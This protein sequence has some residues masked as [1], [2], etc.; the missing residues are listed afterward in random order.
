MKRFFLFFAALSLLTVGSSLVNATTPDERIFGGDLD[1]GYSI[2]DLDF[3][4]IAGS[5]S[6]DVACYN[7]LKK[8]DPEAKIAFFP[9]DI[10][11]AQALAES[12]GVCLILPISESQSWGYKFKPRTPEKDILFFV[13]LAQWNTSDTER[14]WYGTPSGLSQF[15]ICS[16]VGDSTGKILGPYGPNVEFVDCY[17]TANFRSFVMSQVAGKFSFVRRRAQDMWHM[18]LS[19][20]EVRLV[21]RMLAGP[22]A[23]DSLGR[24]ESLCGVIDIT[25]SKVD[26]ALAEFQ[27]QRQNSIAGVDCPIEVLPEQV[28]LHGNYPN[29]FNSTTTISYSVAKME[30]ISLKIYNIK[31]EEIKSLVDG[32]VTA[33]N[34]AI[35]WNAT[36]AMDQRVPSGVYYYRLEGDNF[37]IIKPMTLL[38]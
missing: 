33:G 38:R 21:C 19:W 24:Q 32:M 9:W 37:Y 12:L 2:K 36:N 34:H 17:S 23:V 1:L 16:T 35:K 5:H 30:N 18:D 15:A 7:A 10:Y 11:P 26:S 25:P 28:T 27:R 14:R 22:G 13:C 6:H 8:E 20:Q 31:G 3:L 4:I 29:P